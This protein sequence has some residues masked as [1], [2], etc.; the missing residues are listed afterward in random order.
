MADQ[1]IH[2]GFW[3]KIYGSFVDGDRINRLSMQAEAWWWR[4][5]SRADDHGNMPKDTRRLWRE[6]VGHRDAV[7]HADV[8]GWIQEMIDVGLLAEYEG[9]GKPHLHVIGW[10]EFQP[11]GPKNGIRIRKFPLH[12]DSLGADPKPRGP[13]PKVNPKGSDARK[14]GSKVFGSAQKGKTGSPEYDHDHD[15]ENNHEHRRPDPEEREPGERASGQNPPTGAGTTS[16][17]TMPSPVLTGQ[18]SPTNP[19]TAFQGPADTSTP[20]PRAIDPGAS[21]A[22]A[23]AQR[24][25]DLKPGLSAFLLLYPKGRAKNRTAIRAAWDAQGCEA[26]PEP[27]MAGLARWVKCEEWTGGFVD[28]AETFLQ[29]GQWGQDPPE[30]KRQNPREVAAAK[31]VE[32]AARVRSAEETFA[33]FEKLPR[34]EREALMERVYR[35]APGLRGL[36]VG[37]DVV[38]VE[39]FK[40]LREAV[41]V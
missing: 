14:S 39:V 22:Q 29:N 26:N 41:M 4:I 37:A 9:D 30:P 20:S 40:E 32:G 17:G 1:G 5:H 11:A 36:P 24:H 18:T 15:Y 13:M 3:R 23:F 34:A 7:T 27:V 6:T 8:C 31:A 33:A 16:Q 28:K 35:R 12:P 25:D 2:H 38:K 19:A 21:S 10:Y